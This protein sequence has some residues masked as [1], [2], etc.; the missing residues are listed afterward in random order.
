MAQRDC[1]ECGKI[2]DDFRRFNFC[3][4]NIFGLSPSARSHLIAQGIDPD[5]DDGSRVPG[6]YK[7]GTTW[8]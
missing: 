7:T 1:E 6:F 3:P 2:Y 8:S 4:H 5:S